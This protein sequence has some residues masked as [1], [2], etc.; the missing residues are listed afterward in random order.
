[1]NHKI[2]FLLF[3][4]ILSISI[5]AQKNI[6]L[7][8]ADLNKVIDSA[9]TI[10]RK[11]IKIGISSTNYYGGSSVSDSYI[12]SIIQSGGTPIIIPTMTNIHLLR[13]IL[14]DLDGLLMIGGVD[15]DPEYYGESAIEEL[16]EVNAIRD[17]SDLIL[18][19]LAADRNIPILGICRGEQAL[20]VAFGGTLYQD[21]PT[22]LGNTINHSQIDSVLDA[23]KVSIAPDSKLAKILGV[24]NIYTNSSHHQSVKEIAPGFRTVAHTDDGVIEAIEAYP[25]RK[26]IGVQWH[27]EKYAMKGDQTMQKL[28]DN[29]IIEAKIYKRAKELHKRILSIDSHAD[30]PLAFKQQD[31]NFAKRDTNFVNLPKM[32]EGQ[33]DAIFMAAYTAQGDRDAKSSANAVEYITNMVRQIHD[34]AK[35]HS[36]L[37]GIAT[38]R[39]TILKLKAEGKKALLIGVENGYA[40]GKDI[41]NLKKY[42][43]LGVRYMTLCHT[44]DN[45]IC[46]T[47]SQTENEWGGLSPFGKEVIKEMNRL[48]MMIDISH[49]GIST[50]NDVIKLSSKPIIAS[51]SSVRN[52]CEH[53]RNLTDEQILAIKKNNGVIQVCM[54]DLF[55]N[56]KTEEASLEDAMNHIDYIVKMIGIDH[57]GIGSDFDGGGRLIGLEGA[58]D[59][60]NITIKLIERGYSDSDIEKIWGGNLLRVLE[61]Q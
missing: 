28:F 20:N 34:Q 60:I 50:F 39:D 1:M 52:L 42:Y 36:A 3:C 44:K 45:D 2:S 37:C 5:S 49:A 15:F 12:Q 24:E 17:S 25:Y 56:P 32:F 38:S 57:V 43:D 53:D 23:H 26:I 27:P 22:Q 6:S 14:S 21:I 47:S 59:L 8:L 31:Y 13:D 11:N 19:K 58:H 33:L 29:L 41:T 30:T 46:D 40:I 54:V 48:G 10:K 18:I 16:G 9:Y 7:K 51:H 61:A 35:L 55:I 4:W